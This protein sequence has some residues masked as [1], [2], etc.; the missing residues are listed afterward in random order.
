MQAHSTSSVPGASLHQLVHFEELT[1]CHCRWLRAWLLCL[2]FVVCAG[3]AAAQADAGKDLQ[4]RFKAG[5]TYIY[6]VT[7]VG[8]IGS[9]TE[10]TKGQVQFTAKSAGADQIQLIPHVV[11]SK[12]VRAPA[13]RRVGKGPMLPRMPRMPTPFM[14]KGRFIT[15]RELVIDPSGKILRFSGETS[16]PLLLGTAEQLVV[17]PLSKGEKTWRQDKDVVIVESDDTKT[18]AKETVSYEITSTEG[19]TVKIVKKYELATAV[20]GDEAPRIQMTG[21]S[22]IVFDTA[23][24]L[25]KSGE[26]KGNIAVTEKNITARIPVTA[27]YRLMTAAEVEVAKKEAEAA[28]LKAI[29]MAKAA[30]ALKPISDDDITKSVAEIKEGGFKSRFG[31]DRL[32]RGIPVEARREEVVKELLA[33]LKDRDGFNRA[34]VAKALKT[35]GS[36]KNLSTFIDLLKDE[37]VFA[38]KAAFEALGE[39]KDAKGAEAVA[40]K[41]IDFFSRMDA[42]ASLKTMGKVAEKAVLPLVKDRD[43]AVRMEACKLLAEIGTKESLTALKEAQ[44]DSNGLVAKEAE[45]AVKAVEGR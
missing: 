42:V 8:E 28:R 41:M 19:S 17:E 5:E 3:W 15:A 26:F 10:T 40:P 39:L 35:W 36:A 25:V 7:V 13:G 24:G 6:S 37:N 30:A 2:V 31:A 4:Y 14:R 43:W 34:A 16:L 18:P 27:T 32:A 11:L 22:E 9:T 1:M 45:K 21:K 20:K 38:R 44:S 29:E 12:Q 33:A 23:A